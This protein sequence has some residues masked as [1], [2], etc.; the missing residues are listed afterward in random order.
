MA[1]ASHTHPDHP[2]PIPRRA[3][4]WHRA[5]VD[6]TAP[7]LEHALL[8]VA[9]E[10][11]AAF[12]AAFATARP[13]I[14]ASPGF[15]GVRLTRCVEQPGTYLLLVGWESV[16]AHTEGFRGS[17]AYEQWRTLL[18]HFYDPMPVVEHFTEP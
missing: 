2:D 18:H 9:P 4:T 13:L 3:R 1:R 5:G 15:R 8:P 10:R 12:E 14:E 7:V 17:A 11:A 16:E 6:L